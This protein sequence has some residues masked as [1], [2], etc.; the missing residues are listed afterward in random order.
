MGREA[1]VRISELVAAAERRGLTLVVD[2]DAFS[3][4]GGGPRPV[5]LLEEL[6]A[7]AAELL[8]WLASRT[9]CAECGTTEARLTG[10]YWSSWTESLCPPCIEDV[11]ADLDEH[12]CWPPVPW[13]PEASNP[14][15]EQQ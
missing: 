15:Q 12:D 6:K 9:A 3:A 14:I 5:E 8:T 10:T 4:R 2:G 7:H 13:K 1:P 11:V